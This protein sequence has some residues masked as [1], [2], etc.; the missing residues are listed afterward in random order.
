MYMGMRV[1]LYKHDSQHLNAWGAFLCRALKVRLGL[2][3][4]ASPNGKYVY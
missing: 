1:I 2:I 3:S 4:T